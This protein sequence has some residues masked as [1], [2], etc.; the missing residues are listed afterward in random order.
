LFG[1]QLAIG[2]FD[3]TGTFQAGYYL[4]SPKDR[5][6]L[7]RFGGALQSG[8]PHPKGQRLQ[9]SQIVDANQKQESIPYAC[10]LLRL[11]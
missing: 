5:R 7:M 2:G 10:V 8:P 4:S 6:V 9:R 3:A 1:N 11:I